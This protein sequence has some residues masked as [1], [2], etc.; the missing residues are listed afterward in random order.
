MKKA[1]LVAGSK[2][3]S[4]D[5]TIA[6]VA[7]KYRFV[8]WTVDAWIFGGNFSFIAFKIEIF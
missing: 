3:I 4:C 5:I 8:Q 7:R 1:Y 2:K 6:A